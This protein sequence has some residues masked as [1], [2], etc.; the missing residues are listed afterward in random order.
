M[1]NDRSIPTVSRNV[2]EP[3]GSGGGL[4]QPPLSRALADG[5]PVTS[6]AKGTSGAA[7][8]GVDG[9]CGGAITP[10]EPPKPIPKL[11]GLFAEGM[12]K[13]R[14][15]GGVD[16]GG[17]FFALLFLHGWSLELVSPRSSE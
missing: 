15:R 13:L 4:V 17:M 10:P 2:N 7:V 8:G 1:T 11:A 14:S 6:R 3:R 16:T 9:A 5:P 12:P